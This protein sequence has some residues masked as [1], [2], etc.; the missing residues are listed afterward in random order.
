MEAIHKDGTGL[1]YH[2]GDIKGYE[3]VVCKLYSIVAHPTNY[4]RPIRK[5]YSTKPERG[6]FRDRISRSVKI[7][8]K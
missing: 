2:V 6:G 3:N 4:F 5:N 8:N 1:W 7:K